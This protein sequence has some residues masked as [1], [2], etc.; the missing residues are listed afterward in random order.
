[1]SPSFT[2]LHRALMAQTFNNEILVKAFESCFTN[3]KS[4]KLMIL[5]KDVGMFAMLKYGRN[6]KID[7]LRFYWSRT[8]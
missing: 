2:R 6:E 1:M 4:L 3:I 8:T 5:S 7:V